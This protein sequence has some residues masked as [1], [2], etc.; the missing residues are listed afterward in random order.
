MPRVWR[1][2]EINKFPFVR[3]AWVEEHDVI[4]VRSLS[5]DLG[6]ALVPAVRG[7]TG[8]GRPNTKRRVPERRHPRQT[9]IQQNLRDARDDGA[10]TATAT[11]V[12]RSMLG[13][14]AAAGRRRIVW[15]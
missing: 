6:D 10:A 9:E 12:D 8:G 7:A 13:T 2:N 15:I 4:R 14:T 3:L 5:R 1:P 11:G